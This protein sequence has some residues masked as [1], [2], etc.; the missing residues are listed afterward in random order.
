M[1]VRRQ[2]VL[3]L[4]PAMIGSILGAGCSTTPQR[5]PTGASLESQLTERLAEF[6]GDVGIYVRHLP[7]GFE[8]ALHVKKPDEGSEGP[9]NA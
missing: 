3:L 1:R 7:S 6:A 9:Y 8:L 2:L 5:A 4:L